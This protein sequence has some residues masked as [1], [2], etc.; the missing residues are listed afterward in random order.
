ME[1]ERN[2]SWVLSALMRSE[3]QVH[4]WKSCQYWLEHWLGFFL[5]NSPFW[6]DR[7]IAL[8]ILEVDICRLF[9]TVSIL[10]SFG[11]TLSDRSI[12][13]KSL[14]LLKPTRLFLTFSALSFVSVAEI[15]T[16]RFLGPVCI[17]YSFP[18]HDA[19]NLSVMDSVFSSGVWSRCCSFGGET[20]TVNSLVSMVLDL[21]RN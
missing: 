7:S 4:Q 16:F 20:D 11:R 12:G 21:F 9:G 10:Y 14:W 18:K 2:S 15:E 5:S 6:I 19:V 13:S 3:Q 17:L 8:P 1:Q